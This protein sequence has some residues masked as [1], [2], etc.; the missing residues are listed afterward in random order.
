MN[1]MTLNLVRTA[2]ARSLFVATAFGA[3]LIIYLLAGEMPD[4]SLFD[5][6][7]LASVLSLLAL[8]GG[9]LATSVEMQQG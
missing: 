6:A 3:T 1:S 5:W 2:L 7:A 4:R 8:V 9:V